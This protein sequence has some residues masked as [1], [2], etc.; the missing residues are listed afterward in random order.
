MIW[1]KIQNFLKSAP[2]LRV[3]SQQEQ[4]GNGENEISD[5]IF[6]QN[7]VGYSLISF[8]N[9]RRTEQTYN[10]IKINKYQLLG[11]NNDG[12]RKNPRKSQCHYDGA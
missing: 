4:T 8:R 6:R 11:K 7:Y 10:K 1:R 9:L 12:G 2:S 3:L 5:K